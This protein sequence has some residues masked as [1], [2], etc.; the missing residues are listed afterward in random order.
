M[1]KIILILLI[2]AVFAGGFVVTA[3]A[4]LKDGEFTAQDDPDRQKYAA[5]IKIKVEGGK[6]VKVEYDEMKGKDSKKTSAYVN[7]EMK[8]RNGVAWSDAVKKLEDALVAGQNPDKI[9]KVSGA[10]GTHKRFIALSKKAL[11]K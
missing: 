5:S 6:I 7:N 2:S 11:K 4:Q 8:K 1:K 3:F 10:T 9:D